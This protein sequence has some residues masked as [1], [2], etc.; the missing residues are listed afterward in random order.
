MIQLF[1]IMALGYLLYKIHFT[2]KELNRKLTRILLDVTMPALILS[3]V[4]EQTGNRD[5][6][7]LKEA[8][9]FTA[10]FFTAVPLAAVLIVK[11]MR[12]PLEQQ[13]LYM[14][15]MTYSNVGFMG[16]PVV[17][18]MF[19]SEGILYA[20][21]FN[22][23]FNIASF[24]IGVIQINYG[25]SKDG[26]LID[27]RKLLSPGV[28]FSV[29]ALVFYILDIGMPADVVNVIDM[30]G[31][32]TSPLAMILVGGTLAS[33]EVKSVFTEFRIYPFTLVK[34]IMVP[35]AVFFA[36][37]AV[38]DDPLLRSVFTVLSLMPVANNSVLFSITYG[39]DEQ[40]AARAVFIT[41]FLA[42]F[43]VPFMLLILI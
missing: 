32:I 7:S 28:L 15:M 22:I 43:T 3:T 26:K 40:L 24:T 27:I 30:V 36:M 21:I 12:V 17:N 42:L 23:G 4:L 34:Q 19:G 39:N 8:L 6:G 38:I 18:A 5:M 1:L 35:A 29:L 11:V 25:R 2:D 14:F 9:G 13:G 20:A 16:I 37:N 10:F 31:G 41:T 33:I